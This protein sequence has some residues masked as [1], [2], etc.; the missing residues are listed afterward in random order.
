MEH[1]MAK[2]LEDFEQGRMSRRQ[3]LQ[4]L[5]LAV[6]A[7]SASALPAAAAESKALQAVSVNHISYQV[8]DYAKTRDF[9]VDVFGMKVSNDSGK[10]CHLA[11]GESFMIPRTQPTG[12][13][14]VDHVAYTIARLLSEKDAVGAELKR[15]GIE[16]VKPSN[17]GFYIKDS[18]GFEVQVVLKK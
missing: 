12:A 6:T 8:A 16:V 17:S 4:A 13:P 10:E 3:Y 9:Y 5:A 14:L 7:A 11:V 2:L 1:V 15:R 18:D